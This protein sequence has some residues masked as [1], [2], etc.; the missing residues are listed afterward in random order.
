MKYINIPGEDIRLTDGN[1]VRLAKYGNMTWVLHYG[2]FTYEDTLYKGWYF[3]SV[4][5]EILLPLDEID[6]IDIIVVSSKTNE[7]D[8]KHG[9]RHP[10]DEPP[11]ELDCPHHHHHHH[12]DRPRPRPWPDNPA[13]FSVAL[14]EQLEAA[15][16]TVNTLKDLHKLCC[17]FLPD[18]KIV[19]VNH[20]DGRKHRYFIW[21]AKQKEWLDYQILT[22]EDIVRILSD[23][24]TKP[25]I[26]EK[27]EA[28]MAEVDEKIEDAKLRWQVVHINQTTPETDG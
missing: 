17:N 3:L 21:S 23:Y 10:D 7:L 22:M 13:Y 25:E 2:S 12:D 18:G 27:M 6:L 15:F 16:I 11:T 1:I 24:Y 5:D 19:R 14:K 28:Q 20:A 9:K 26:D 4:P 8:P